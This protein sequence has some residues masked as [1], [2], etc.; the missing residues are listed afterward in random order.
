MD[1]HNDTNEKV[2]SALQL[3]RSGDLR[4]RIWYGDTVTGRAWLEEHDVLGYI[5]VSTGKI[6]A[7]LL[8]P[9]QNSMGGGALLDHCIVRIMTTSGR[10]LYKH[11]NFESGTEGARIVRGTRNPGFPFG[12]RNPTGEIFATF[13]TEQKAKNWL[14]FMRGERFQK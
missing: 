14:A 10:T 12:V 2:K 13:S 11:P 3:A 9:R 4:V 7:P 6:K 5:G 1:F 8:I